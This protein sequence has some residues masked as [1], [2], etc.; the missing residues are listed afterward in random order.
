MPRPKFQEGD[1][2]RPR[3]GFPGL[4][5]G[6]VVA[7]APYSRRGQALKIEDADGVVI[8]NGT[9][10]YHLSGCFEKVEE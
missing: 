8:M 7:V 1:R 2:V 3:S 9:H 5:G 10:Q 4:R 6:V